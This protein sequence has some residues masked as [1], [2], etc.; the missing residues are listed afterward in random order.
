MVGVGLIIKLKRIF[1]NFFL[2]FKEYS[3]LAN[4]KSQKISKLEQEL[5]E[6]SPNAVQKFNISM[7]L[8][9]KNK[10]KHFTP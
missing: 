4:E 8:Q 1:K 9:Y 5:K 2:S 7:R 3:K 10:K 6:L